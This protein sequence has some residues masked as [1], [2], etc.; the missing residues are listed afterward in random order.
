ML[1]APAQGGLGIGDKLGVKLLGL[2]NQALV[3]RLKKGVYLFHDLI[4]GTA[5]IGFRRFREI[6]KRRDS[7]S[8]QH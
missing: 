1:A 2:L 7:F 8:C 4:P 3:N 5:Q 6:R